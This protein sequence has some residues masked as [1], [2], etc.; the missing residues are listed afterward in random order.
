M[1]NLAYCAGGK[2]SSGIGRL[3]AF[4]MDLKIVRVRGDSD[5]YGGVFEK[6]VHPRV[7]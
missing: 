3:P 4:P 2:G 6:Y 7:P 5:Y 1:S